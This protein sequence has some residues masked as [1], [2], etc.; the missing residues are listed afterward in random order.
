[1]ERRNHSII[2]GNNI[3]LYPSQIQ[4]IGTCIF[5][6][7]IKRLLSYLRLWCRTLNGPANMMGDVLVTVEGID[8]DLT[9]DIGIEN[10]T[11]AYRVS[12]S[13]VSVSFHAS[14]QSTESAADHNTYNHK[15]STANHQYHV[16]RILHI[17]Y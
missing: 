6:D 12:N 9:N 13:P 5:Y 15:F 4:T 10:T 7:S 17:F 2:T 16:R 1:M 8:G 11:F 14:V 3:S